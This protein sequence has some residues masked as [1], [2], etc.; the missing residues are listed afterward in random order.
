M[1]H[2]GPLF[3]YRGAR[4]RAHET[5]FVAPTASVIGDVT[6]GASSSIWYGTVLRGDVAPIRIGEQ[7]SVQDNSVVHATGGW[8]ETI[9]GDRCTV[10]H[11]VILHGCIVGNDV[12]VGM[13]SIVLDTAEIGDWVVLGAGSLV[14]ARTKIPSG[15][16]AMGRPAKPVR[17]L[18]DEE[19]ARITEAAALYVGYSADHRR[20]IDEG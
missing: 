14:T 3:P 4:P 10:G 8:S 12:L 1:S 15:V 7:T 9:V 6:I 2:R 20:S 5:S 17:D 13:G 18:T 16:L 19:R 11:S